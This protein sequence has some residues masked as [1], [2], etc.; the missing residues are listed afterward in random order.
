MMTI[1]YATLK[2][3][4]NVVIEIDAYDII[5]ALNTFKRMGIE[6]TEDNIELFFKTI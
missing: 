2:N 4:K 1:F 3:N 6:T 5:I